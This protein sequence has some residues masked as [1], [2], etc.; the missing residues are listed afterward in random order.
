MPRD[1]ARISLW[2]DVRILWHLLVRRGSGTTQAERLESFYAGQAAGYDDF[3]RRMLHGRR[4]LMDALP[5]P[6]GAM[7][8]DLGAGTGENAEHLGSRLAQ[9]HRA[10]LVDLSPSL[11]R[12]AMARVERHQWTNV[13]TVPA[14]ATVFTPPEPVDVVTLSYSLTMI[15][16]WFRAVDHALQ[17]LKPGGLLG[18]VDFYVSRKFPREGLVRHGWWTRTLWPVWFAG[19]NVHLSADHLPYLQHRLETVRL[20]ERRGKLPYLP[21]VRVPYYVFI[22]RK[23]ATGEAAEDFPARRGDGSPRSSPDDL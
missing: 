3:R 18:V 11:L 13:V 17:M 1:G 8:V 15:P 21:L 14:D 4:E 19:D 9:L 20:E 22:G 7:W 6:E 23:P 12:V 2:N 5:F 16:D 10:Y